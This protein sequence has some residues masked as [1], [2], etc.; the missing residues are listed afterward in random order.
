MVYVFGPSGDLR[1]KPGVGL[2]NFSSW[3]NEI[4]LLCHAIHQTKSDSQDGN[5]NLEKTEGSTWD[6]W[7]LHYQGHQV[8]S[9]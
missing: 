3:E 8:F 2:L 4:Q 6:R 9:I 1:L 5:W 7:N